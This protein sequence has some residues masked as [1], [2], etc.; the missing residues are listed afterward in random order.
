[1]GENDGTIINSHA[2][3]SVNGINNVGGLVGWNGLF[4]TISN[5]YAEGSVYGY[6]VTDADGGLFYST[7]IGGLAG[8]NAGTVQDSHATGTVFTVDSIQV[9]GLVG[10]NY[11]VG[12]GLDGGIVTNSWSSSYINANWTNRNGPQYTSIGGLVGDNRG[13]NISGSEARGFITV[14]ST[15]GSFVPVNGVGGL[16]GTTDTAFDG[17][18]GNIS[19]SK[20]STN[21]INDGAADMVGGLVGFAGFWLDYR[22]DR[23]RIYFANGL[24]TLSW[25]LGRTHWKRFQRHVDFA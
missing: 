6:G 17:T 4:S 11:N 18:G 10:E 23:H 24:W 3:V 19:N 20:S 1:M 12:F 22:F 2:N 16:V 8:F 21:I 7:G 9:G 13:G 25:R 14:S 15:A 5:S